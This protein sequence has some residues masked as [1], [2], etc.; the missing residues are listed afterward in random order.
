MNA[1]APSYRFDFVMVVTYGRTGS[2]LLMGLLNAIPGFLIRGENGNFCRHLFD[3]HEALAH[4]AAQDFTAGSG[5]PTHPWFGIREVDLVDWR[6]RCAELIRA[7][8][9]PPGDPRQPSVLGFKEIHYNDFTYHVPRFLDFM[10]LLFPGL[11]IIML[12]RDLDEV[13]TSDWWGRIPRERFDQ[14]I[15]PLD[16]CMRLFAAAHPSRTYELDYRDIVGRG[17]RLRGLF[18]FLGATYDEEA[19]KAVLSV[20]HSSK[21][22]RPSE[23]SPAGSEQAGADI[24]RQRD[25]HGVEH[26]S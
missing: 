17:E 26:K 21:T 7:T 4:A 3:A 25:D 1:P 20:P 9:R 6:R 2:T 19:V 14:V 24:D 13:A 8:L 16:K 10:H 12:H 22:K 15:P 18:A 23:Q 11:G 5:V